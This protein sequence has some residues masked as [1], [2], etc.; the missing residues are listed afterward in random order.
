M[1]KLIQKLMRK[2]RRLWYLVCVFENEVACRLWHRY[3][4]VTCRYLSPTWHD[5]D[6][7]LLFA[8]FQ[9]LEDFIEKEDSHFN[10]DVYLLYID[11]GVERATKEEEEWNELRQLYSWWSR[12]R[13]EYN[14]LERYP[15]DTEM[16][17]RLASV[18]HL[19]WT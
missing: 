7:V 4:V 18:R 5:R 16:L 15:E 19:L 1:T 2:L 11:E 13:H 6:H 12:R 8:S 17:R 10:T 3:N 14:D 9:I